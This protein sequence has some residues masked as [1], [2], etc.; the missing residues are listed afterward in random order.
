MSGPVTFQLMCGGRVYNSI[1]RQKAG[2]DNEHVDR[3]GVSQVAV[4]TSG[5]PD[6]TARACSR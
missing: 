6:R 4:Q 5:T 1:C 3:H 2:R